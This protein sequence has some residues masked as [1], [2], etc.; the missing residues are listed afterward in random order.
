MLQVTGPCL[1]RISPECTEWYIMQKPLLLM[2]L[3]SLCLL[4]IVCAF[5][6]T[7]GQ[8]ALTFLGHISPAFTL[9]VISAAATIWL[10]LKHKTGHSRLV[11]STSILFILV[12][13]IVIAASCTLGLEPPELWKLS[14]C[15]LLVYLT[16]CLFYWVSLGDE[17]DLTRLL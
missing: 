7:P 6:L 2:T 10:K 14:L 1:A 15:A 17:E 3:Q 11:G 12:G 8:D 13:P 5:L 16:G 4:G 9:L